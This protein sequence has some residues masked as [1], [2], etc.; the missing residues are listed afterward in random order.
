MEF[1]ILIL[2]LTINRKTDNKLG[3]TL[4]GNGENAETKKECDEVCEE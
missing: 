3:H 4:N 1:I 2:R